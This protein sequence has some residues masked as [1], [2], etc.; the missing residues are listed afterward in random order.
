MSVELNR[1]LLNHLQL[2]HLFNIPLPFIPVP[3]YLSPLASPHDTHNQAGLLYLN[4]LPFLFP[5]FPLSCPEPF[6]PALTSD[7]HDAIVSVPVLPMRGTTTEHISLE[8][9]EYCSCP[10]QDMWAAQMGSKPWR[11]R[12]WDLD[13]EQPQCSAGL[14]SPFPVQTPPQQKTCFEKHQMPSF[15]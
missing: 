5:I 8:C 11:S 6:C 2:H 9:A 3:F 1:F 12:V 14:G 4:P 15:F 13:W 7:V 10:L